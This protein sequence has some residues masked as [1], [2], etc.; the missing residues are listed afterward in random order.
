MFATNAIRTQYDF[1]FKPNLTFVFSTIQEISFFIFHHGDDCR[2]FQYRFRNK[3]GMTEKASHYDDC[4]KTIA[5]IFQC[6]FQIKA[7]TKVFEFGM[8]KKASHYDDSRHFQCRFRNEFGMTPL[9]CAACI[10]A[11]I[12]GARKRCFAAVFLLALPALQNNGAER[13]RG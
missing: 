6:R 10:A 12:G 3:F 8:T 2:Y 4:K 13:N 1:R 5:N 11:G 9:A 7:N